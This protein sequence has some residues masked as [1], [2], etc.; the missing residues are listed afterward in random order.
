M[1][2]RYFAAFPLPLTPEQLQR[3]PGHSAYQAT[4]HNGVASLLPQPRFLETILSLDQPRPVERSIQPLVQLRNLECADWPRLSR[5]LAVA[6][7]TIPPFCCLDVAPR[8]RA[9]RCC[10]RSTRRGND[11]VLLERACFVA[12]RP[13]AK[14]TTLCGAA[15][16]VRPR[17]PGAVPQ[18]A[19]IMVHPWMT[20]H[21]I[22]SALLDQVRLALRAAGDTV[23]SSQILIGNG[24]AM[25][26]H[27]RQGFQISANPV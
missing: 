21:G 24:P 12:E 5:L 22:G 16:V 27:W 26:W 8:R 2:E 4:M 3:L 14:E 10:L 18:L 1:M 23:L 19:W 17:T 25:L 9:A 7:E 20:R 15:L 6:F 13:Q 11:G